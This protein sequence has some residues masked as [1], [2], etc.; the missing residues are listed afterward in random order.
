[1][2]DIEIMLNMFGDMGAG[3]GLWLAGFIATYWA[4]LL[5]FW[6]MGWLLDRAFW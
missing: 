2:S 6:T 1:M 5:V 4:I 3:L